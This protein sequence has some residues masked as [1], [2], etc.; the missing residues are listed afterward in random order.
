MEKPESQA[1]IESTTEKTTEYESRKRTLELEKQALENKILKLKILG[2]EPISRWEIIRTSV[3][4]VGIVVP[5][6]ISVF[7]YLNQRSV[8]LEQN[9]QKLKEERLAKIESIHKQI[10]E[11]EVSTGVLRLSVYGEEALPTILGQVKVNGNHLEWSDRTLAAISAIE[12]IGIDKLKESD[13]ELLK[14]KGDLSIAQIK[15]L[16]KFIIQLQKERKN[17]KSLSEDMRIE[18]NIKIVEALQQVVGSVPRWNQVIETYRS[19][20]RDST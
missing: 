1:P 10:K 18:Q 3:T 4:W 8:E 12:R 6:T 16:Q 14:S 20:K 13:K 17:Y 9:D 19:S 2:K 11:G 7:T 5:V 15:L